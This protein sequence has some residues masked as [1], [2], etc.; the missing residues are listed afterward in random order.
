MEKF[1]QKALL[2]LVLS[3]YICSSRNYFHV[4]KYFLSWKEIFLFMKIN[5]FFHENN[6]MSMY[7]SW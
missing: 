6:F 7:M 3:C 2:W 4:N 5:I 1:Y